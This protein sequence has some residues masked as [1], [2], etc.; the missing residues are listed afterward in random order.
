MT[1]TIMDAHFPLDID[2]IPIDDET[3]VV[4]LAGRLDSAAVD[5]IETRFTAAVVAANRHAA[6][7][8]TSVNF[9]ASMAIRLFITS[10]RAMGNKGR[11]IALFGAN[12][13]VASVLEAVA[14]DQ[15]MPVTRDQ[16]EALAALEG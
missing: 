1:D 5:S 6:I 2:V 3:I 7:D 10:A 11:R 16:Q 12:P 15:L 13:E 4:S 14:L 8:L 9:L